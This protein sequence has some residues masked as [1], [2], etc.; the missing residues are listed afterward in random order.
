MTRN[1]PW[2]VELVPDVFVEMSPDLAREKGIRHGDWVAVS[3]KRGTAKARAL[4]TNRFEPFFVGGRYVHQIGIPW[5]WGYNGLATGDSANL[6]T[7]H[8]GDA[9]MMIPEYKAFLCQIEK[10]NGEEVL[11]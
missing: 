10:V 2:L 1:T 3:T 5:H 8:V 9:N 11:A 6:L 7:S 4:I